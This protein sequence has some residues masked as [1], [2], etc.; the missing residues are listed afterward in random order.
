MTWFRV[1]GAGIPAS[2]KNAMNAVFNK[3]FGTSGQNYPPK[4]WPD[5]VNLLGPL[6]E[7]TV[8]G[9]IAHTDDAADTVPVKSVICSIVPKQAGTGTPSPTN[10]R[11]LSG[12]TGLTASQRGKNL[13]D[14]STGT[15]TGTIW[16]YYDNGFLF[17][18]GVT[19]TF[20]VVVP[21]TTGSIAIYG[22]DHTTQIAYAY[23]SATSSKLTFTPTDDVLGC[24]RIYSSGLQLSDVSDAMIEIG[25]SQTTFEAYN[26][27][28]DISDSWSSIG[29]IL[30]GERDLTEG[31]LKNSQILIDLSELEWNM[32]NDTR[33]R[34]RQT[35]YTAASGWSGSWQ[36]TKSNCFVCEN[37]STS[38]AN[39]SDYSFANITQNYYN[40]DIKVPSGLFANA[41][42]FKA[43]L[44]D[45]DGNGTHAVIVIDMLTSTT[46]SN[47][48]TYDFET[49]YA[50]NNFFSDIV[51]GQTQVTY[52]QDIDL[53][54]QA[55][56][57]S[58]GLM[59]ASR[60]VTQLVGEESDH[61]QVNELVENDEDV[62]REQ[63]SE[64]VENDETEQ[65]GEN[66]AR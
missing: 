59:M 35:G 56:S 1:G 27:A 14:S 40:F 44:S 49:L 46:Y 41:D 66:D 23:I 30:G 42:A 4:Q 64:F 61:D 15:G 10:V 21:V 2:L 36:N 58:R 48:A 6:P 50:V 16:F 20:S 60:P 25:S 34:S 3:K 18:K 29:A 31:T 13:L 7:K 19:Y 65:E 9:A 57:S 11:A 53:A 55:V 5:D 43:W 26:A 8:A 63:L 47:L 54:L 45:V 51:G 38:F 37:P 39:R 52:R 28:A 22:T 33:F 62:L 32:D 24:P 12:Y 17:R